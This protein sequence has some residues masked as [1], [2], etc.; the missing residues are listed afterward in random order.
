MTKSEPVS[1]TWAG[2]NAQHGRRSKGSVKELGADVERVDEVRQQV[3]NVAPLFLLGRVEIVAGGD[4]RLGN[5]TA[6]SVRLLVTVVLHL[7]QS[8]NK[9][10]RVS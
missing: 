4:R 1:Q 2:F 5:I 7:S 10:Q 8:H 9:H 6:L 3:V